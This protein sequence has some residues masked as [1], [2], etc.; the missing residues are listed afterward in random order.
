MGDSDRTKYKL[1]FRVEGNG[2]QQ[3][4]IDFLNRARVPEAPWSKVKREALRREQ[5]YSSGS[6]LP[7]ERLVNTNDFDRFTKKSRKS[8]KDD[9]T[10]TPS[11]RSRS[12]SHGSRSPRYRKSR[13]PK[14]SQRQI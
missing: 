10:R 11:P 13:M 3:A 1:F 6:M 9:L 7:D 12:P 5:E 2:T 8:R 4:F 14:Q